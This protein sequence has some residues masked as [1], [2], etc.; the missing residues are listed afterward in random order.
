MA[1][2]MRQAAPLKDLADC[3]QIIEIEDKVENFERLTEVLANDLSQLPA[4][5]RPQQWRQN[6]VD[7]RLRFGWADEYP[8]VPAVEGTIESM[9]AMVCQR[10]LAAFDLPLSVD[11]KLLLAEAGKA[12]ADCEGYEAWEFEETDVS[13]AEIVEEALVM[14]L[15]LAATHD[16]ATDCGSALVDEQAEENKTARPFADLKS[17]LAAQ[18]D[19][20]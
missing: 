18:T 9:V 6:P 3:S 7:I 19:K 5:E 2:P 10:C 8:G 13:P 20:N 12:P 1:C 17:L 4:A 15:P 16:E 14:A 11:L